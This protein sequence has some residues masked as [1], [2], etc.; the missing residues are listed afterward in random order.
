[1]LM[2]A[3]SALTSLLIYIPVLRSA[4]I[5]EPWNITIASTLIVIDNFFLGIAEF[6]KFMIITLTNAFNFVEIFRRS[7]L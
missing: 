7:A 2:V 1:M 4:P 5:L 6:L 3:L